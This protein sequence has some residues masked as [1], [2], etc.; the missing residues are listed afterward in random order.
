MTLAFNKPGLLTDNLGYES[1]NIKVGFIIENSLH[2]Q[3]FRKMHRTDEAFM[4]IY[5]DW[6]YDVILLF[7]SSHKCINQFRLL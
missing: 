3:I 7:S 2:Y 5:A 1:R 6:F 4:Q